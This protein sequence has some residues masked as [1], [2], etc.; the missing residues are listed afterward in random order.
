M[1]DA[2]LGI[3]HSGDSIGSICSTGTQNLIILQKG[4]SSLFKD[5]Q[6]IYP[7]HS[8]LTSGTTYSITIPKV[9]IPNSDIALSIKVGIRI[10]S[11]TLDYCYTHSEYEFIGHE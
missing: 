7:D 2:N 1:D 10:C 8:N 11:N 4:N 3:F 6:I 9:Y 5:F